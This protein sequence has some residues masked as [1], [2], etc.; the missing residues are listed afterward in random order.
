MKIRLYWLIL[1]LGAGFSACTATKKVA[2]K[3]A[4]AEEVATGI[5][6]EKMKEMEYLFIEAL[7]QKMVGNPQKAVSLLSS[8]LEIDPNSS[9]AMYELA[10]LH[11]LN[12]D[13][14]SASLLLEKAIK[15]NPDNKWYKL[16][17]AKVYQQTGKN[18]ESADLY[19]QLL[20]T[21]PEN[22]EFLY[23]KAMLL[24]KA[25]KFD[26]SIRTLDELEK[27]TGINEQI[28]IAKQ[29]VYKD[30]G[31]NKEAVSEIQRLINSDPAEA[32]YYGLLADLYKEQGDKTSALRNYEKILEMDPGNG[33]VNFSLASFYLE[34]GDTL[35]AYE[36]TKKGFENENVDLDTK[37][38]LYLLHTGENAQYKLT[39]G[40]N[41]ELINILMRNN[42]EDFR[43]RSVY[44]EY[45]IRNK[46]NG[47]AREQL[48]KVI[49][50]G[51]NEYP[52]WEQILYLDNDL[53][54]WEALYKHGGSALELFPNQPQFYF[55]RAISALQ[56]EKFTEAISLVE[57]GLNYVVDNK[58]LEGQFKFLKGE[59]L[60]KQ[61]R[62]KEAFVL[63]DETLELDP[64]NYVLLNNY[65]YYLSLAE[66]DLEKAERMS[67]KVILRYPDNATYLDT[68]AWVLFKKKNYS[69]AK[70]Y[71]ES[72]LKNSENEN[73]TLIEHYGD[74]LFMSGEIEGALENW[75]KS[76]D[77][78]NDSTIL[79]QKIKEKRYIREK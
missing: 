28:S 5:Q 43:L 53:Q 51:T 3:T 11:I 54:D 16:L 7:K 72:A 17:L 29:D 68:Y 65:A 36:F 8:C 73:S 13:M 25:K 45:L 18:A 60:Y 47:E 58:V 59:A 12:N 62:L 6:H 76:L 50:T 74:I 71:M 4:V 78:G 52:V 26:E 20:K 41:E 79:K 24:A 63:F 46:R 34:E 32:K 49:E 1:V 30:A 15:I 35:R 61:N 48:L 67:G 40:Q 33:F 57:D 77:L 27:Q 75:K 31:K 42:P 55:F 66:T 22:Q 23:L 39:P 14:T 44:A 2:E 19:D 10:N 37:I 64:E 38:Q 56:L 70:F 9:S 69:L 21:D